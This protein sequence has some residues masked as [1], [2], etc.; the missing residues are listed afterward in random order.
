MDNLLSLYLA[1]LGKG[2]DPKLSARFVGRVVEFSLRSGVPQESLDATLSVLAHC[3]RGG[4][5]K[6]KIVSLMENCPILAQDLA[7]GLGVVYGK[8]RTLN[9]TFDDIFDNV[10][11]GTE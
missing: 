3:A 2:Y 7:D 9:L 4:A 1:L 8:L 6:P 10:M 11:A 5:V